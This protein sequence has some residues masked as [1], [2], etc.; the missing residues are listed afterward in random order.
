M[1]AGSGTLRHVDQ[2]RRPLLHRFDS[3]SR[4]HRRGQILGG[5]RPQLHSGPKS[6]ENRDAGSGSLGCI[7]G[8]LFGASTGVERSWLPGPHR[9]RQMRR[10]PR[11]GVSNIRYM[12]YLLRTSFGHLVPLLEDIPSCEKTDPEKARSGCS[13]TPR[14]KRDPSAGHQKAEGGVDDGVHNNTIDSGQ[15]LGVPGKD[16]F[17]QRCESTGNAGS[18]SFGNEFFGL[19]EDS[20]NYRGE[21]RAEGR[22][23]PRDNNRSFRRLL[24][25]LL[26][27]RPAPGTLRALRTP[28]FSSERLSVA[29]LLQQYPQPLDLHDILTGISTGLQA[30]ALR[31]SG[32]SWLTLGLTAC[33]GDG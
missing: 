33:Q 19:E 11:C 31:H 27:R 32:G 2:Q 23:D 1:V 6:T 7:F 25:A 5:D 16:V 24:A 21:A 28:R 10:F 9:R 17:V 15:L 20:G 12:R 26:P 30:D 4:C 13:A 14:T 22:E 8:G 18:E 3:A 29:R